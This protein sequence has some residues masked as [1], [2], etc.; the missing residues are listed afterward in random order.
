MGN[1]ILYSDLNKTYQ[2]KYDLLLNKIG[3]Y[4]DGYIAIKQAIT[5][6]EKII[7]V[8]Q[9]KYCFSCLQGMVLQYGDEY[10][11]IREHSPRKQLSEILNTTIPDYISDEDIVED[12]LVL[13]TKHFNYING[14]SFNN[15]ILQNYFSV[16]FTYENFSFPKI[17]ELIQSFDYKNYETI[18][19]G[20]VVKKVFKNKIKEWT[21]S[22]KDDYQKNII[23]SF[24]KNPYQLLKDICVYLMLRGY[25]KV[26]QMDVIGVISQDISKLKLKDKPFLIEGLNITGIER[27]IKIYLNQLSLSNLSK[28][29]LI[30]NVEMVSGVL[31]DELK[32]VLNMIE[33]NIDT[34]DEEIV[35]MIEDKFEPI[36]KDYPKYADRLKNVIP[37]K[38]PQEPN[39]D[40]TASE[41]LEW[42]TN[43]YLPYK[44]WLEDNNNSNDIIDDYASLYGD[45]IYN[46]YHQLLSSE[47]SML[48]KTLINLNKSLSE[49]IVSLI[50]IVD[51]FN[52][53]YVS[54][55]KEYFG[56]FGFSTT[57]EKPLI[58][59]IPTETSVSKKAFF[60]GEPYNSKNISYEKRCQEWESYYNMKFKYLSGTN[61]MDEINDKTADIYILNYTR[62]DSILHEN[63]NDSA[64]P[65]NYRIREE[66]K[67]LI[68]KIISFS[69]RIGYENEIKIYFVSDHGSTKILPNQ[70][71]LIDSKYYKEKAEDYAHRYISLNDKQFETYKASLGHLCYVMDKNH[72]G[73]QEN[74]LIAKKY[75]RFMK[76]DGNYYVHGGITP[77]ENI[78]PLLKFEKI[79]TKLVEPILVLRTTEFRYSVLSNIVFT[80]KNFNK[81]DLKNV[82]IL[83]VNRNV[84]LEKSSNKI[85]NIMQES[86]ETI[87]I[88]GIRILKS[89]E[90]KNKLS[91]KLR[92]D[93][94]NKTYQKEYLFEIAVKS[95]QENKMDFD[96]LF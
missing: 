86:E 81:Y 19:E 12:Q 64:L 84:N 51:N 88:N 58:T 41:W 20:K 27:N 28:E 46:N 14:M 34:V 87:E 93:F 90:E 39:K 79:D 38:F 16:Y 37:P 5:K 42:A 92:Y 23:R 49:N 36:M 75:Y 44:F 47:S 7:V 17:I 29:T 4:V 71:N 35:R 57:M 8:V 40:F 59:M 55:T 11:E 67:A 63:Q 72:Y 24:T 68:E 32:F 52:F 85:V 6:N 70:T 62:I 26:L 82:E 31:I 96:D 22:C 10:I 50:V 56:N 83:I 65:I 77:E 54:L 21:S 76:T 30:K 43:E 95:I 78:V 48:Y 61:K 53:K 66:L 80:I 69:K 13:Q 15:I 89:N 94:L 33:K 1:V 25:P 3:D 45:W 91:V 74:Y 9:N 18:M 73:T 2:G 60:S